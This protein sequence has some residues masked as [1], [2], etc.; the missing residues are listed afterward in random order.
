MIIEVYVLLCVTDSWIFFKKLFC[1][2]NRENGPK[3]GFLDLLG[4]LVINFFWIWSVKK[5]HIIFCILALI[6]YLGN[7]VLEIQAK[8]LR[9]QSDCR[10]SRTQR[11]KSLIFCMLIQI[12]GNQKLIE[13]YW[14]GLGQ[15]W[16]WSLRSKDTKI[17]C[18]SK[19]N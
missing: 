15:K 19:R 16:V 1:P 3:I 6:P 12:N 17:G 18:V 7:L 11:W 9:A 4:N 5:A 13:K 14:G 10:I 8:M 2:R